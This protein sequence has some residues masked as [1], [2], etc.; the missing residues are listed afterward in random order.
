LAGNAL[1]GQDAL[2]VNWQ[3]EGIEHFG[4]LPAGYRDQAAGLY[5]YRGA[6][7]G[8]WTA[9]GGQHRRMY[10]GAQMLANNVSLQDGYSIRCVKN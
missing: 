8:F 5:Y 9:Q 7:A 3:P 6:D 10:G 2:F 1:K 4:A